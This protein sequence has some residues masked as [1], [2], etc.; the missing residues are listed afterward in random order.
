MKRAA[1]IL[2]V[3]LALGVLYGLY[4]KH[5]QH[6]RSDAHA[7]KAAETQPPTLVQVHIQ[8]SAA[9]N[10][11]SA[12]Q[13][14]QYMLRDT[15]RVYLEFSEPYRG[16]LRL[17]AMQEDREISRTTISLDEKTGKQ[18]ICFKFDSRSRYHQADYFLLDA[19]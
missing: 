7:S 4:R 2:I 6:H 18:S 11:I 5:R 15:I 3:L 10:G 17:R 13:A 14:H 1:L 16:T 12:R 9:S 8:G 19:L